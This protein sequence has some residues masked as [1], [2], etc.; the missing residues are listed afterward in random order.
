MQKAVVWSGWVPFWADWHA[1][2]VPTGRSIIP[3]NSGLPELSVASTAIFLILCGSARMQV[4]PLGWRR[5]MDHLDHRQFRLL[6]NNIVDIYVDE[7]NDLYLGT[8]NGGLSTYIDGVIDYYRTEECFY[9][10]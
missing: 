7:N 9:C 5:R 3:P 4:W 10:R 2:M 6:S 1:M 8:L